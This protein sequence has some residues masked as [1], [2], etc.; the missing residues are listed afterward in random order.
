V[1]ILHRAEHLVSRGA[2]QTGLTRRLRSYHEKHLVVLNYH[3][4]V[5][6]K[7]AENGSLY[8][9]VVGITEFSRQMAQVAQLFHPI[10]AADIPRWRAGM[11]SR[12]VLITFDDGYRNNLTYA[13]P[14]LRTFGIPALITICPDYVGKNDLLWPTE[15]QWRV[16]WWPE[17]VIPTPFP[18]RVRQM[19]RTFSKRLV[20]ANSLREYCKRIPTR[21]VDEYLVRLRQ[22]PM[23][24]PVEEVHGFLSWDEVRRLR[25]FGF[26]IGSHTMTHPILTQLPPDSVRSELRNSKRIIEQRIGCECTCFAYP[27]G[28]RADFSPQIVSEV[29]RTGYE[30]AFS[31]MGHLAAPMD[32]P[33]VLDRIYVPAALSAPDFEARLSGLHSALKRVLRA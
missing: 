19:P 4:V 18:E 20:L 25:D 28:S 27:N 22:H 33:H 14:I 2:Q 26:E 23:K 10:R 7:Y 1:T 12:A 21:L 31:V 5:P 16:L 13:A 6:D 9:N 24:D 29:R 3:G 32:A 17:R 8:P 11:Y 30:F 15:I